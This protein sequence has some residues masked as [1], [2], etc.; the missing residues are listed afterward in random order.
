MRNLE[1]IL[2]YGSFNSHIAH[3][4]IDSLKL[5]LLYCATKLLSKL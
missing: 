5:F 4:G 1:I 2:K 3:D